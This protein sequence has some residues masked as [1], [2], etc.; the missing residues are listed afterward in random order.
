MSTKVSDVWRQNKGRTD[1]VPAKQH[2]RDLVANSN[3]NSF[4]EGSVA[5]RQLREFDLTN[6]W[7]PCQGAFS[8]RLGNR[9]IRLLELLSVASSSS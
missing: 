6:K 3:K 4:E 9:S 8:V 5:D 2:S 7:G 1:T